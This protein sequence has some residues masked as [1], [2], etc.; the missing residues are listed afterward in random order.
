MWK[1][2][3]LQ[4]VIFGFGRN[5]STNEEYVILWF[6]NIFIKINSPSTLNRN[7]RI[8]KLELYHTSQQL[9]QHD[10]PIKIFSHTYKY[11]YMEQS[12]YKL[13]SQKCYHH[14]TFWSF[15]WSVVYRIAW[16][17][18]WFIEFN[19]SDQDYVCLNSRI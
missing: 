4:D 6:C 1:A 19:F 18:S 10:C 16:W 11:M 8:S 12:L 7:G 3:N 2:W 14:V 5:F 17:H 9:S 15:E 13:L